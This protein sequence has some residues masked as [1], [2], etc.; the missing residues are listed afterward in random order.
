MKDLLS[1][2][3]QQDYHS[4]KRGNGNNIITNKYQLNPASKPFS[5]GQMDDVTNRNNLHGKNQQ[6]NA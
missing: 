5:L 3:A 4:F 2:A 6:Q 1:P